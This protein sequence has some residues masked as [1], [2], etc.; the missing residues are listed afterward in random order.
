MSAAN[1]EL[2][3]RNTRLFVLWRLFFNCR[4]YYPVYAIMFLDYGLSMA[5]FAWLNAIWA[6]AIVLLEVPSG[7][8]ADIV[9]RKALIVFAAVLMVVEMVILASM[10]VGS[11]W[12]FAVFAFNRVLSGAAEAAASGADEALAYD[13]LPEE[14]RERRWAKVN[15]GLMRWS[16]VVFF[17]T[18]VL[19]AVSYDPGW[20]TKLAGWLGLGWELEQS[21][22]VRWPALLNCFTGVAALV[23]A[24]R[25]RDPLPI[26]KGSASPVQEAFGQ[27]FRTTKWVL[28][29]PLVLILIAVGLTFD[30]IIRTHLTLV[31]SY[32]RL[33]EIPEAFYGFLGAAASLIGLFIAGLSEKMHARLR[34]ETNL[35][36]TAL[37]TFL[38]LVGLSLAIPYWGVL[39]VIPVAFAMRFAMYFQ[40]VYLNEATPSDRRATTLS[41]KG[42]SMN[43]AY[44]GAT[45]L[46]GWQT[47][48]LSGRVPVP[49]DGDQETAVF[50]EALTWWPWYFLVTVGLLFAFVRWQTKGE[51]IGELLKQKANE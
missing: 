28:R 12:L 31:S 33:V 1:E 34:P 40:T 29:T 5:E 3:Q 14:G 32:Y 35:G 8:L 44:G 42:L 11:P 39:M 15:A 36:I 38:G 2:A 49:E 6:G 10:P 41:I 25:M 27:T 20:M 46:F 9:G 24:L 26:Q 45:L 47:A 17:V 51:K 48:Y 19:G 23:V 13:S 37:L 18:S 16:S 21:D 22:T 50:G 30:S 43:L 4:F 7:A